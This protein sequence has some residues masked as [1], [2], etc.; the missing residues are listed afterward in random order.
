MIYYTSDLHLFHSNIIKHCN[1]PFKTVEEMNELILKNYNSIVKD[2]DKVIF[3]GDISYAKNKEEEQKV[4]EFLSK[5]KGKKIL[6]SGNHDNRLLRL[7]EFRDQFIR[8]DNYASIYDG[9]NKVILCHYPIE[10]WDGF[11][12]D[13]IHLYGHVHNNNNGL[14]DIKNRYN[15]GVDV[16][17]FKPVTLEQLLKK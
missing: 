10:E 11:F 13:S 12:K 5:F 6:I 7:K 15:V 17:D 1:R 16:N 9:D 3:L 14:K 4:I 8:I 2:T